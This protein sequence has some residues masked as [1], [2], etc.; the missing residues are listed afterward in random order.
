MTQSAPNTDTVV[1]QNLMAPQEQVIKLIVSSALRKK[2]GVNVGDF[3]KLQLFNSQNLSISYY[4]RAQ[5]THSF[6]AGPGFDL[7]G[8][9]AFI[10]T[11]QADYIYRIMGA[12]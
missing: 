12:P 4:L 11:Q 6:K 5:I 7:L 1:A 8:E 9:K 2:L 3:Y 10:S